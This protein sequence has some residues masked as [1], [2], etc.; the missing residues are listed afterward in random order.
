[1]L[2]YRFHGGLG[3]G[4]FHGTSPGKASGYVALRRSRQNSANPLRASFCTMRIGPIDPCSVYTEYS[5]GFGRPR[6]PVPLRPVD[7]FPARRLLYGDSAPHPSF[8]GRCEKMRSDRALPFRFVIV[9]QKSISA[10]CRCQGKGI[11]ISWQLVG[12]VI[13]A[14]CYCPGS[15]ARRG[16]WYSFPSC[17]RLAYTPAFASPGLHTR[18]IH[19]LML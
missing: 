19:W 11:V 10:Q 2:S 9:S 7:G 8:P 14:A 5:P 17:H 6:S 18:R 3:N 12:T 16:C 15:H 13:P 4:C 1:M